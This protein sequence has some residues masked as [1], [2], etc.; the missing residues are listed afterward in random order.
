ME[1]IYGARGGKGASSVGPITELVL[2]CK[3]EAWEEREEERV[4]RRGGLLMELVE[5]LVG[6]R[7]EEV[8]MVRGRNGGLVGSEEER[9]V[10][11]GY[12]NKIE[13][14]KSTFEIAGINGGESARRKV[15]DWCVDDITF[16]VMLDPVVVSLS[17]P[18]PYHLL[19]CK[20]I[21]DILN[22]PEQANPTTALQ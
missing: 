5:G 11:R 1:E 21:T 14:L 20:A 22:R 18:Y 10:E 3:K 19:C 6:R 13:E 7:R 15:P 8:E 9:R 16:S 12:E 17:Q 2:R 4:R